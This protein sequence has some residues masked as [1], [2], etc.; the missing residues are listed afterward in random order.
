MVPGHATRLDTEDFPM[1]FRQKKLTAALMLAALVGCAPAVLQAQD[2]DYAHDTLSGDWGG[3]RQTLHDDGIDLN[4]G[5]VGEFAHNASGGLRQRDAYADQLH[6]GADFDFG[7][8]WNWQGG[9][10]HIAINQR[11]GD[12]LDNKAGLGT[13]FETQEIYGRGHVARLTQFF[14]EQKLWDNL[15]DVR[16]GRMVPGGGGARFMAF[17]CEFQNLIACGSLPGYISNGWYTSPIGQ[18][19]AVVTINPSPS[20]YVRV[21]A[22]DSNA[23][24]L[25]N[26]QGLKIQTPGGWKNTMALGEIGWKS[27][28]GPQKLPGSFA[29]GGWHNNANYPD[30]FTDTRG[31]PLA[32]SADDGAQPMMDSSETGS[33]VMA[34]Q[35][36]TRDDHGGGLTLFGNLIQ[37][38]SDTDYADQIA[39]V[40]A[41]YNGPFASRPDDRISLLLARARVSG[42]AADRVRLEN[43][44]AA[45]PQAVPGYEY[46]YE[47]NYKL[48]VLPGVYLM[49]N[50]QYIRHP[51]G[52]NDQGNASVWGLRVSANF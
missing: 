52:R 1:H 24:N 9:S 6:V 13:L 17:D 26:S 15:V 16:V 48:A 21:G 49:P 28:L 44:D 2:V 22:L 5:Y 30:L 23:R 51:G 31:R 45:Q 29:V 50:Y 38:D 19:G 8:L 35:Q 36:V 39:E 25:E 32:F 12:L 46:T 18:Y 34:R 43:L 41:L 37:A 7:K 42:R 33:Y 40:G 14:F 47:L 27:E 20:W 3:A 4:F 10:F 11:N